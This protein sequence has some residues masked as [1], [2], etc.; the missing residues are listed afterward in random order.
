[1]F[2]TMFWMLLFLS[3]M[4]VEGSKN[5]FTCDNKMASALACLP[6]NYSKFELPNQAGV[7]A[8][9]LELLIDEVLSIDDQDFSITFS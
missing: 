3:L 8:V 4:A 6:K 5:G 1:M 2:A 9:D 7:N